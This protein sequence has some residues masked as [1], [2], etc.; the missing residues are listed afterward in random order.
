M[1]DEISL[2]RLQKR[3]RKKLYEKAQGIDEKAQ[4]IGGTLEYLVGVNEFVGIADRVIYEEFRKVI[5]DGIDNSGGSK[6]LR[7]RT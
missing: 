6:E 4:G 7:Q 3:I 1:I 5:K 2:I